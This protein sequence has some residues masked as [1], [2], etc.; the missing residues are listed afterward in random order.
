VAKPQQF[1]GVL[2]DLIEEVFVESA[3]CLRGTYAEAM[4]D[5]KA[6][7]E[8]VNAQAEIYDDEADGN[9]TVGRVDDSYCFVLA[10][11]VLIYSEEEV[12][13][14]EYLERMH[15][16]CRLDV[17]SVRGEHKVEMRGTV[18]AEWELQ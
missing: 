8:A 7:V 15:G 9:S 4:E 11:G 1:Q 3:P 18:P 17:P 6:L 12:S 5:A 10:D 16:R 13:P 2:Y 14:A